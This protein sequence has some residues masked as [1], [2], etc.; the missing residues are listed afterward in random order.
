MSTSDTFSKPR[1]EQHLKHR[2][3]PLKQLPSIYTNNLRPLK[4]SQSPRVPQRPSLRGGSSAFGPEHRKRLSCCSR[5]WSHL[6]EHLGAISAA[7]GRCDPSPGL[8]PSLTNGQRTGPSSCTVCWILLLFPWVSFAGGAVI[9][10]SRHPV[11]MRLRQQRWHCHP[12][13]RDSSTSAWEHS[14]AQPG[15]VQA[16][17]STLNQLQVPIT[18]KC[19]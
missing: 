19:L 17:C 10:S 9:T 14:A 2:A 11:R 13:C 4:T 5:G 1:S 12:P 16:V 8:L 15:P 3:S 18:V 7:G 6:P